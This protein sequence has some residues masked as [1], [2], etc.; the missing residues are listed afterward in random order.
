ML[1]LASRLHADTSGADFL[2][3]LERF[4]GESPT[5]SVLSPMPSLGQFTTTLDLLYTSGQ[6]PELRSFLRAYTL[7]WG[8]AD[9]SRA[10]DFNRLATQLAGSR[11]PSSTIRFCGGCGECVST[12]SKFCPRCE[13]PLVALHEFDLDHQV[14]QG[15]ELH[16]PSELYVAGAL[17]SAG[18]HLVRVEKGGERYATSLTFDAFGAKV[19]VDAMGVGHP[20]CL[21]LVAVT[22]SKVDQGRA[23]SVQGAHGNLA[24]LLGGRV[25]DLP[26]LHT[27]IVSLGGV[28]VNIDLLGYERAGL[29]ICAKEQL[30]TLPRELAKIPPRLSS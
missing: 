15:I 13:S 25:E 20:F 19:D 4:V 17:E 30:P 7:F 3:A 14:V 12:D 29:T 8:L 10:E 11:K 28:D 26:P 22:T 2:S 24:R 9:R 1:G 18:Y 23:M 27:V 16:V 6:N 5:F 21:V